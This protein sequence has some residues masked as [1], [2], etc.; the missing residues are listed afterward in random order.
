MVK[1]VQPV[2]R[3]VQA[4]WEVLPQVISRL[5]ISSAF[6]SKTFNFAKQLK[7][8]P[9]SP[10]SSPPGH[11]MSVLGS[12]VDVDMDESVPDPVP[13]HQGHTGTGCY[14]LHDHEFLKHRHRPPRKGGGEDEGPGRPNNGGGSVPVGGSSVPHPNNM[15]NTNLIDLPVEAALGSQP[16]PVQLNSQYALKTKSPPAQRTPVSTLYFLSR[17]PSLHVFYL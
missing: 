10:F 13:K 7:A 14:K 3:A 15:N 11:N 1:L 17:S 6:A 8:S 5:A 12:Q 4:A 9:N 16:N 2:N